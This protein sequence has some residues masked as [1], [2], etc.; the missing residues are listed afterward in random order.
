[1]ESS[2]FLVSHRYTTLRRLGPGTSM[3]CVLHASVRNGVRGRTVPHPTALK[4]T[5]CLQAPRDDSPCRAKAFKN[6][7]IIR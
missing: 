7:S 3:V 4:A 6:F 5:G 2:C 1:M